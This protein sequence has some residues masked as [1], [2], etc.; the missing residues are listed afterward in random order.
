MARLL[1]RLRA[2]RLA[3][4]RG[5]GLSWIALVLLIVLVG[6]VAGWASWQSRHGAARPAAVLALGQRTAPPTATPSA[7]APSAAPPAP[8]A[9]G[10]A[11]PPA[12]IALGPVPDPT[13]VQKTPQGPLPVISPS[14]KEAWQAYA[15]PFADLAKH[16][17][18]GILLGGLGLN[19]KVTEAAI[20]ELPGPVTLGFLPYA[21]D[22]QNWILRA[23]AAGHEV[24]L[25]LPMEPADYPAEDPGPHALLTSLSVKDNGDRLDWVLSRGSG[26]IGV[27]GYLGS[28]FTAEPDQIRP[29]LEALRHRG[30][31]FL[32]Q[33]GTSRALVLRISRQI[34]L[35]IAIADRRL[36]ATLTP[37]AIAARLKSLEKIARGSGAA[38]GTAAAYPLAISQIAAWAKTLPA[39]DLALA[40]VSAIVNRQ[41]EAP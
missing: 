19:Q 36:D 10:T 38:I 6:G 34:G 12:E 32:D 41:S 27:T 40:P 7:A 11:A 1:H 2:P 30:L 29:V 3:L 25:Q 28:K 31:M 26:Y 13:L 22:L 33:N 35:P 16:P 15:R 17:R 24:I 4:R 18:I 37:D 21:R 14:G 23:R 8:A 5:S 9:A 39:E 20:A